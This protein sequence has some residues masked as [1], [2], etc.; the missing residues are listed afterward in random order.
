MASLVSLGRTVC[1]VVRVQR[2]SQGSLALLA[3]QELLVH[4][5]NQV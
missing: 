5:A 4:L 1:L 3:L 2:A